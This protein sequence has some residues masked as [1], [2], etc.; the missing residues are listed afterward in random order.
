MNRAVGFP[1]RR[2]QKSDLERSDLG[3]EE[4]AGPLLELIQL[5][6]GIVCEREVY[7]P[8]FVEAESRDDGAELSYSNI[9]H[10]ILLNS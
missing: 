3:S 8:N 5:V 2:K 4:H 9:P 10:W 1:E 6:W 7:E